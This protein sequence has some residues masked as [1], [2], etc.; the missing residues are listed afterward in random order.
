MSLPACVLCG[1]PCRQGIDNPQFPFCSMRCQLVDLGRW[2]DGDYRIPG[3]LGD[4]GDLDSDPGDDD[5]GHH[6][7]PGS[8]T[9]M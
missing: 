2:L 8:Q 9:L 1:E 6:H 3:D 7:T 4:P 5:A